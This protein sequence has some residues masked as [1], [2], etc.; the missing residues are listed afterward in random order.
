MTETLPAELVENLADFCENRG[1]VY[2]LLS[3][4]YEKEIDAAFAAEFAQSAQLNSEVEG[5]ANSFAAL[6]ADL[7]NCDDAALEQ[8]AVVFNRAFFGMGP[9]TAQKAFP[10]ESVY[11]SSKGLMMQDAYVS[12]VHLYREA[13]FAK[14]PDFKEPE[15]HLAVELAFMARLCERTVEA[16]RAGEAENAEAVLRDQRTFLQNH[17]LNWIERFSADLKAAA[18]EGF[19]VDMATFTEAYLKADEEAL[20]EVVDEG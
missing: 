15:D 14:N 3:R 6:Q 5:L 10:Y 17:L 11:T 7:A 9:R 13:Q 1:R 18:E 20:A 19:Y 12:V 8:L 16:L 2:A 4:C